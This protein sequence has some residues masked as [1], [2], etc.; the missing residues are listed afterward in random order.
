MSICWEISR[1]EG[2]FEREC[3]PASHHTG[4]VA[5]SLYCARVE[6]RVDVNYNYFV[7]NMIV[8]SLRI[9]PLKFYDEK[10]RVNSNAMHNRRNLIY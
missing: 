5:L 8:T 10:S 2:C 4:R 9:G 6:S 7:V 3:D 1:S